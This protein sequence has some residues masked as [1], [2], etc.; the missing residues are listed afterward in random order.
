VAYEGVGCTRATI[1]NGTYPGA[2]P[3]GVVTRGEP[4]GALA[5]FLRWARS[6]AKARQVIRTQYLTL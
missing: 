4:R 2:R 6:S 1:R 3:L 5:R